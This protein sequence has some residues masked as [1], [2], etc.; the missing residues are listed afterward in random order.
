[1]TRL[2]PHYPALPI[3]LVSAKAQR[4]YATFESQNFLDALDLSEMELEVIDLDTPI[5]DDSEVPF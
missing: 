5:F 3:M 1:M 4:A 2:G